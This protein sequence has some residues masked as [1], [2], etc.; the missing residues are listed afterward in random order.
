MATVA[1]VITTLQQRGVTLEP[2]PDSAGGL[3]VNG[4]SR[5]TDREK[6]ALRAHKNAILR[7][8]EPPP[9]PPTATAS[10]APVA[11]AT[12]VTEPAGCCSVCGS[13]HFWL[14]PAGWHCWGC[15]EPPLLATTLCL[16]K[17][18][19]VVGAAGGVS[20]CTRQKRGKKALRV[21]SAKGFDNKWRWYLPTQKVG[22]LGNLGNVGNVETVE[23][24]EPPEPGDDGPSPPKP[25]PLSLDAQA[26]H[27]LLAGYRG[28]EQAERLA[29]RL[30]WP[31]PGGTLRVLKAAA[32]LSVA[33]L[34][35][36]RHGAVRPILEVRP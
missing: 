18:P 6:N 2:D 36:V 11:P 19:P 17:S 14:S 33:G 23:P 35:E 5:L 24:V 32:E 8:L 7:A 20:N 27:G 29:L 22:N 4:I 25:P 31:E 28:F 26:L 12:A 10:Q 3:R 13:N 30:R 16:S 1:E 15:T 34:A 9:I 21:T